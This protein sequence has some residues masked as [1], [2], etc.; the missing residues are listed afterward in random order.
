[1]SKTFRKSIYRVVAL[2]IMIFCMLFTDIPGQAVFAYADTDARAVRDSLFYGL[3]G[4]VGDVEDVAMWTAFA[5]I[6]GDC[7]I[8]GDFKDRYYEHLIKE[9]D[10]NDW[11]IAGGRYTEYSKLILMMTAL[12][13]DARDIEGHDLLEYLADLDLVKSQ[14]INGVI[15]AL[16]AVNC[17]DEY[18]I[19]VIDG[20]S[21]QNSENTM[22]EFM[23]ENEAEDGGWRIM[24]GYADVDVTAMAIQALS[25]YYDSN[26]RVREKIDR[27][28][29]W[30]SEN[31]QD[32]G[33]YMALLGNARVESSESTSQVV[34]ALT[35][36]GIDPRTDE[37]FI[38]SSGKT[39]I[40]RLFDHYISYD[41]GTAGFAHI[42]PEEGEPEINGLAT[43]EGFCALTAYYRLESGLS[44]YYDLRDIEIGAESDAD[45]ADES[46]VTDDTDEIEK[47]DEIDDTDKTDEIDDINK[48]DGINKKDDTVEQDK[49]SGSV[50]GVLCML[51]LTVGA[52]NVF[53]VIV[54]L[55]IR[56]KNRDNS[57]DRQDD[58]PDNKQ[59]ESVRKT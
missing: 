59:E 6:R 48:P 29:N 16:I 22:L 37:R 39:M 44:S 10:E 11:N 32:N 38:T 25:P 3:V 53:F 8:T 34:L 55:L 2:F 49:T 58:Q 24:G 5:S 40:G 7:D 20:V 17:R 35:S 30:L 51:L 47:N 54:L 12:G 52:F 14:G 31:Q 4:D 33:G 13:H 9:L 21:T 42:L 28:V 46:D 41:D 1:M 26:E 45:A 43:V 27:A 50:G 15:Y 18:E 19:P 36:L 56:P 57:E 23:L